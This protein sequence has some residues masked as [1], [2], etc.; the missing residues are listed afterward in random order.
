MKKEKV[1][2]L[3]GANV[4]ITGASD[5]IGKALTET[6]INEHDCFVLGIA[7]N[8][9][10]LEALK[11]SLG[12]KGDNFSYISAD[13]SDENFWKNISSAL[14]ENESKFDI[15]INSAG[16][17][18][19]FTM[20]EDYDDDL[21]PET[22]NVNLMGT[23]YA[24]RYILPLL[25]DSARASIINIA[26][27]A[28]VSPL[29]GT[30]AYSASKAAVKAFSEAL[31][32]ELNHKVYVAHVCPGFTKTNLFR[33]TDGFFDSKIISV[34]SSS[35]QKL[36]KKI[37]KGMKNHKKRM[38]FGADANIMRTFYKVAPTL[39]APMV[40]GI[41]KK[42]GVKAFSGMFKEEAPKIEQAQEQTTQA[43]NTEIQAPENKE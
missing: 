20:F 40:M 39:T 7:R 8:K 24:V 3:N 9:T 4:I 10:K 13:V 6:L 17:M 21:F 34:L 38:I 1:C 15:L 23:Y 28:A 16:I 42:S 18:P 26:S 2:W 25:R 27:A 41:M 30:A 22:I 33:K 37:I 12:S 14:K 31:S 11:I 35:V 36:T 5:G 29:A 43:Q 19:P 32:A